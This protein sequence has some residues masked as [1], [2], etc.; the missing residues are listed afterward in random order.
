VY[1][2]I[3]ELRDRLATVRRK[4]TIGCVPTMGALHAG[5]AALIERARR[6]CDFVVV[7]IFVN[8]IQ[9]NQAADFEGYP[10]SLER[11]VEFCAER[12]VDIIFAPE[13]TELYATPPDTFVEV[14]RLTDHLCGAHRPGHFRGVATVVMKLFDIIQPNRA[15]FGEKDA[16]QL[17]VIRRLVRDLNVP[18]TIVGVETVRES[19]GLAMSSR[20]QH[21]DAGQRRMAT[22]LYRALRAAA[23]AV[24][25]GER[26]AARVRQAAEAVLAAEP[27][28]RVEYLEVVDAEEMQ[29]LDEISVP[30][31]IAI[32]AWVGETRL[33]DNVAV[34]PA[35]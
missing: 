20:N 18:V 2:T 9:F 14:R 31:R 29:P 4:V 7:T 33:I 6:E 21:L 30:A 35:E 24:A 25:P 26:D 3:R 16:Q 15:Y 23:D 5:H 27:E 12:G 1:S 8:R 17:A 19:D 32:A 28:V 11:D 34:S 10:R 13:D 22:V